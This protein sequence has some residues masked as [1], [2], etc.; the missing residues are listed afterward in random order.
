MSNKKTER[1]EKRGIKRSRTTDRR[2]AMYNDRPTRDKYGNLKYQSFQS[3]SVDHQARIDPNRRWFG[4]SRT[5]SQNEM[6]NFR[7]AMSEQER[8]PYNV[9]VRSGKIPYSL[10]KDPV[11]QG[12]LSLLEVET[13]QHTFGK[14]AQ[15]KRPKLKASN[16]EELVKMAQD[17][18]ETYDPTND[19]NIKT[20]M[21]YKDEARDNLFSKGQSNRIWN[22]LYKV[23]DSSDV[24][25]QVLDARDPMGTR[26][27]NVEKYIKQNCPHKNIVLVMNKV[28]LVPNWAIKRWV[29]TLSKEYPT[30]AFHASATN[31]FGKGSLIT[32]L[33]QFQGINSHKQQISVGFVGYPNVGKSSVI[34]TISSKKVCNVAPIPGETKVWQYITLFK[35]IFL[36]D[37]PGVVYPSSS[38]SETD[39]VLKGVVRVENLKNP[40]EYIPGLLSRTKKEY[41][42]KT[43]D[44][45]AW[46][47]HEDFLDQ[48]ARKTGKL[49][50]KGEP[51]LETSAKMVLHDWLRGKIPYFSP[52]PEID[53]IQEETE[54]DERI[55]MPVQKFSTIKTRQDFFNDPDMDAESIDDESIDG[56]GEWED[57]DDVNWDDMFPTDDENIK[58]NVSSDDDD[59]N[60]EADAAPED[61]ST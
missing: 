45:L 16:L 7:E 37:C 42:Q 6:D 52:P 25:I 10:L 59:A 38:E 4:P 20:D 36:I 61:K 8:Q 26:C 57:I 51:D 44:I 28:D 53:A 13:F 30:I 24:I 18:S 1:G 22:E 39:I 56:S 19:S 29:H 58:E 32:L 17:K 40:S 50:K 49:L 9:L 43:Y 14:K 2:L 48:F 54:L 12:K 27:F 35:K 47:D 33:R 31:S 34:N 15:R 5:S 46:E 41:I 3:K 11:Q 21:D 55:Q 60:A 23:I